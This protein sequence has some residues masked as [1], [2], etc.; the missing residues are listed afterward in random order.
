VYILN[1]PSYLAF[2]I[3]IISLGNIKLKLD[4]QSFVMSLLNVLKVSLEI[5]P[6]QSQ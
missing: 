6:Q 4:L 1:L 3:S 5:S 2:I